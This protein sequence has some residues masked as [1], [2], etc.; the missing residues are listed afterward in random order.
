MYNKYKYFNININFTA[1]LHLI[2]LKFE[3]D[4]I[5]LLIIAKII[6]KINEMY[7]I[8]SINNKNKFVCDILKL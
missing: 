8:I 2:I 6:K 5:I 7:K 1:L 4:G 3:K